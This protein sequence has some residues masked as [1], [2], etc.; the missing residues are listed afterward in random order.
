MNQR[1][2]DLVVIGAGAAGLAAAHKL[3]HEGLRVIVLEARDR[4]GGRVF[5]KEDS[6]IPG[7]VELGAEFIHGKPKVLTA[8][9]KNAG[10]SVSEVAAENPTMRAWTRISKEMKRSNKTDQTF[11][12]FIH[13]SRQAENIKEL[14]QSYVEGF[15]AAYTD[16]V[17]VQSLILEN[18]AADRIQGD[19]LFRIDKGFGALMRWY[20][21]TSEA[22]IQ[23]NAWVRALHWVKDHVRVEYTTH[24]PSGSE[25]V[26]ARAALL[27]LPLPLLQNEKAEAS[28]RFDP[29]IP[30]I[31]MAARRLAMGA[32]ARIT[33]HFSMPIWASVTRKPG[34]L[35][36]MESP[37][38]TWWI[39]RS[40]GSNIITGWA[41]GPKAEPLPA[42]PELLLT[43]ALRSLAKVLKIPDYKTRQSLL[44]H[45][46]HDWSRDRFSLG[47]YS[48]TPVY[49]YS[50]RSELTAPVKD[51]LFFA[52]EATNT[53]GDHGTV[54]GAIESGLRAATQ[55]RN[56]LGIAPQRMSA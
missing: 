31:R 21:E 51:T 47:A 34:F 17:S 27:T 25:I 42:H 52:G 23:T 4:V 40:D 1:S 16:R 5:T 50:A 32:A 20:A 46:F 38:P 10:L 24:S 39:S 53:T 55:I 26:A 13:G 7:P 43:T 56:A 22:T 44:G 6:T 14:A 12:A 35:F 30:K 19:R 48:Y 49:R 36:S 3:A 54:H 28:I 11:A 41:G 8:P 45:Y 9:L 37:F 29:E 33:L 18:A 15:H 2:A